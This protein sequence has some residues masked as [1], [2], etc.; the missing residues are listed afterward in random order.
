MCEYVYMCVRVFTYACMFKCAFPMFNVALSVCACVCDFAT[1]VYILSVVLCMCVRVCLVCCRIANGVQP[2]AILYVF[3]LTHMLAK[4][5]TSIL[6]RS[7]PFRHIRLLLLLLFFSN[8]SVGRSISHV[9][10]HIHSHMLIRIQLHVNITVKQYEYTEF[11]TTV[12]QVPPATLIYAY[13]THIS[14][15]HADCC[16]HC[17]YS[18]F[19]FSSHIEIQIHMHIWMHYT[20]TYALYSQLVCISELLRPDNCICVCVCE[21]TVTETLTFSSTCHAHRN[22]IYR[23]KRKELRTA[24]WTKYAKRRTGYGNRLANMARIVSR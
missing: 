17:V 9:Y 24:Y 18:L 22:K 10:K 23:K 13:I 3:L 4:K 15:I 6:I 14:H 11:P 7:L 20:R 19:S 5:P 2:A 12:I 1:Y 16:V 8:F 21:S